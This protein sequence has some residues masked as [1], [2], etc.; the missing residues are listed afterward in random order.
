MRLE[1]TFQSVREIKERVPPAD[2]IFSV[3]GS[4]YQLDDLIG[5]IEEGGFVFC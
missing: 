2:G 1:P 5:F 4:R 3:N